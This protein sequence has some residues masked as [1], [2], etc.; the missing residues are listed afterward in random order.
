MSMSS[1]SSRFPGRSWW[2]GY[3]L[4]GLVAC[5]TSPP[6]APPAPVTP[7]PV[8]RPAIPAGAHEYKV[9]A[10]E[11]LLQILVYRGGAM[12]R[13]GH[14]HVIAS[15][16]LEGELHLAEDATATRFE[17]RVPVDQLTVDE[18]AMGHDA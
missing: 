18:P 4:L 16:H 6:P 9:V 17:I 2:A 14:N 3:A 1:C 13:L 7:P 15:R 11:S 8:E 10:E 5:Q 12:A